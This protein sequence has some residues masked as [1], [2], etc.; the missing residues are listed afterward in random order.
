MA[1]ILVIEDTEGDRAEIRQAIDASR[2]FDRILE[3]ADG[4][5][6]LKLLIE[7]S[8]WTWCSAIWRCRTRRREAVARAARTG[9]CAGTSRSSSSP[10]SATP[11]AWRGCFVRRSDTI[12][13]PFHPAELVARLELHLQV[14]R[15]QDERW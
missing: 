4:I 11:I 13:K 7:P 6:G 14:K 5:H 15:L 1:T 12:E 8:P 3:A 10:P 2:L 9:G